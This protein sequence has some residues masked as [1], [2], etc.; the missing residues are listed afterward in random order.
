MEELCRK[1]VE[2]GRVSDG[3]MAVVLVFEDVL[4]LTSLYAQQSRSMEEK[5]S[6]YNE[7]KNMWNMHSLNDFIVC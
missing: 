3:M 2:V 1:L 6:F 5:Y 7:L 4:R